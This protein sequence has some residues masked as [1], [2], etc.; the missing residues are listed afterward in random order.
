MEHKDPKALDAID[1]FVKTQHSSTESLRTGVNGDP[2]NR[3]N[4]SLALLDEIQKRSAALRLVLTCGSAATNGLDALGPLPKVDACKTAGTHSGNPSNRSGTG[5][6]GQLGQ[7]GQTATEN[8][9]VP[10]T[11]APGDTTV[12]PQ[13]AGSPQDAPTS[14][15]S[16]PGGLLDGLHDLVHAK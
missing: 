10:T 16:H 8:G 7:N 15:P 2:H 14:T 5:Q 11:P 4:K 1:S 3:A 12:P 13:E 6:P 9:A